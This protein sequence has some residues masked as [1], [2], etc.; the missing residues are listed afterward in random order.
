MAPFDTTGTPP[1]V[2]P[3]GEPD[4]RQPRSSDEAQPQS[5][6]TR[7]L[8]ATVLAAGLVAGAIAWLGGEAAYEFFPA[9]VASSAYGTYNAAEQRQFDRV[10][11][12][13]AALAF[14]LLGATLGLALGLAG[15]VVRRSARA[16]ATAAA[17]GLV[18][19]GVVAVG[20]TLGLLAVRGWM[21]REVAED[22]LLLALAIHSGIWSA[23]GAAAGLALGMGLGG[24]GRVGRAVLGGLLGA[25]G[26]TVVYVLIGGLAFP[27]DAT[28]RPI[29]IT[30]TPRLLARLL[31]TTLTAFGA[32]WV[33][34][35]GG[36]SPTAAPPASL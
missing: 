34:Q 32:A 2:G 24:R 3:A 5:W 21:V 18:V 26:A 11:A 8:W 14:G 15:G 9:P 29:A 10:N 20:A 22:N 35:S 30:W 17:V 1:A 7:R 27:L 23:I 13:N 31:V 25:A 36:R 33:I 19:G 28:H 16:A 4:G 6:S 12:W